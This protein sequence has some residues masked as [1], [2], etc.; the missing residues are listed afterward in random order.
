MEEE[1]GFTSKLQKSQLLWNCHRDRERIYCPR[2]AVQQ[3][4]AFC[5]AK[6]SN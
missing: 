5:H 4:E 2:D 6:I 1:K 3:S